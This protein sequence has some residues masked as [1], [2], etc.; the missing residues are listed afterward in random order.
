ML[1]GLL[2]EHSEYFLWMFEFLLKLRIEWVFSFISKRLLG[3]IYYKRFSFW[4]IKGKLSGIDV[5][6]FDTNTWALLNSL[7]SNYSITFMRCLWVVLALR[8]EK[9]ELNFW[10]FGCFRI[11]WIIFFVVALNNKL[12]FLCKEIYQLI[13]Y[14]VHIRR[15]Q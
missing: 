5:W 2:I 1:L 6:I 4:G 10:G 14:R 9:W 12:S 8:M 13:A 11:F 3:Y 7:R 15:S